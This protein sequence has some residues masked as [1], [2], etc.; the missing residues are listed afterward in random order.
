MPRILIADDQP[1]LLAILSCR[2]RAVGFDVI[3]A[4]N[5]AE[6]VSMIREQKPDIVSLDV[7]MPELNGFQVC[8]EMKD[9]DELAEIPI[10][11][12]TA[13]SSDADR[14]WGEEVGADLY[15]TKPVDPASVVLQVRD[16][17]ELPA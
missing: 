6:A 13:K 17:L 3:E 12:V 9:D 1:D 2:F 16:L 8:R 4:R 10:V 11:L 14:F 5:G 7:T 15:L